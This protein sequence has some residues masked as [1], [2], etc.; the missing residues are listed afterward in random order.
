M[1]SSR[2]TAE[3]MPAMDRRKRSRW[4]IIAL[5]LGSIKEPPDFKWP[6]KL[7]RQLRRDRAGRT[8]S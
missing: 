2:V 8:N 7:V 4:L 6:S 5:V 1:T 3:P